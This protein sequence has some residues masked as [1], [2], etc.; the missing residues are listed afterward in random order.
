MAKIKL[1]IV[2]LRQ[3]K[4]I[5]S[6]DVVNVEKLWQIMRR[7]ELRYPRDYYTFSIFLNGVRESDESKSLCDGDEVVL[8]PIFSGG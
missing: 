8:V 1:T 7:V 5:Q 2:G 4:H 6:E 3:T